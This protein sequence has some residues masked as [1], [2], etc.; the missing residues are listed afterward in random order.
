VQA[1]IFIK[2]RLKGQMEFAVRKPAL[3]IGLSLCFKLKSKLS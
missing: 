1:K 3:D 2:N